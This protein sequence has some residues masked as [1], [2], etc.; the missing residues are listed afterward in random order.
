MCR[1]RYSSVKIAAI[2]LLCTYGCDWPLSNPYDRNLCDPKCSDTELCF[3]RRCVKC[4]E[5][6]FQGLTCKDL[7]F[8][9]GTLKCAKDGSF[10]TA[11]CY[12]CG[13]GKINPGEYC[14]GY[15]LANKSCKKS[16]YDGGTLKCSA[17]CDLD[18]IGCYKC[19]DGKLNGNEECDYKGLLTKTC[20]ALKYDGGT[21][22]CNSACK[23]DTSGCFRCGDGKKNGSGPK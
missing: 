20:K 11:G 15:A 4:V 2:I 6:Y 8:E 19:G 7:G 16:G 3:D 10:D 5:N 17:K 12:K 22:A 23:L 14:D 21:L 13:D 18:F 9:G 1:G